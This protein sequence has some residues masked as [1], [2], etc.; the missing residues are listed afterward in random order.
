MSFPIEAGGAVTGLQSV[1][2]RTGSTGTDHALM[3]IVVSDLRPKRGSYVPAKLNSFSA[4]GSPVANFPP[5]R[6]VVVEEIGETHVEPPCA[7]VAGEQG[8]I[9]CHHVGA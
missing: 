7:E 5:Q 1:L 2:H 9:P 3:N 8:V 6:A 4:S